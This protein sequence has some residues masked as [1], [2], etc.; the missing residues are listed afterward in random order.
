MNTVSLS[1][2]RRE[3]AEGRVK[4]AAS[5]DRTLEEE[6]NETTNVNALGFYCFV[7]RPRRINALARG[8]AP[9]GGEEERGRER[10]REQNEGSKGGP[11]K[12][13]G[14]KRR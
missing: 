1:L 4:R 3:G 6:Q 5:R 12:R 14:E 9:R 10:E 7:M 8:A 13:R 11:K 2:P